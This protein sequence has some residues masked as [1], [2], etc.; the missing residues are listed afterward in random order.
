MRGEEGSGNREEKGREERRRAMD[1]KWRSLWSK[2]RRSE[3]CESRTADKSDA[4]G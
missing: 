3:L 2:K 4:G 1:L